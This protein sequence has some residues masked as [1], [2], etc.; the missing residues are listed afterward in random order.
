[1][2]TPALPVIHGGRYAIRARIGG[3]SFGEV[4][5]ADDILQGDQVAIKLL[6]EHVRIDAALLETQILTRLRRNDRIVTIRNVALAPPVPFI[7]MDYL[8]AGSVGDRLDAGTVTLVQAV[9][10]TRD[11][12]D[13][14]AYAHD[15]GV[16][17]RDVKPDNLL[18]D[19]AER[20]VLSDFGIAEDTIRDLLAV[21]DVYVPHAAPEVWTSGT[22]QA[23]DIFAMGCTLYR[24]LTGELPFTSRA[25]AAAG[26]LVDPHR[27]NPQIPIAVSRVVRCAL[28][29]DPADRYTDGRA[30]LGALM[31]CHVS[32]SWERADQPGDLETWH[33][34]GADGSYVLHLS[35]RPRASDHT[36]ALT[37]DKGR[38]PRHVFKEHHPR[39][40]DAERVRRNLLVAVTEHGSV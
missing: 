40:S 27:L 37:R 25:A 9:R 23:T 11:A 30:M 7:A 35:Q 39:R 17:H 14:L 8:P 1:M 29:V 24:L 26:K 10:W 4:C 2:A 6:A 28:A 22:S 38:G 5:L 32:R 16:L 3:G 31:A 19:A 13:G 36:V 12:L 21:P 15:E 20:A 34:T 18:L 33:V